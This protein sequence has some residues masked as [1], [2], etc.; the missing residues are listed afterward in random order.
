MDLRSLQQ[1]RPPLTKEQYIERVK[2]TLLTES[3]QRKA[4][5]IAAGFRKTLK[6]VADKQG[7]AAR[8]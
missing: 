5:N 8:S 1:E 7:A 3:A 6:E 4:A 2:D